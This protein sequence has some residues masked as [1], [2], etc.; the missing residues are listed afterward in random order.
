MAAGVLLVNCTGKEQQPSGGDESASGDCT[1]KL[2]DR[3]DAASAGSTVTLDACTY[4]E[5]VV[6][7]KNITLVGQ[8][9]T[10]I[11]GTDV[12]SEWSGHISANTVPIFATDTE[13]QT[14]T[15]EC[16]RPE[17]ASW[18]VS[19]SPRLPLAQ[20]RANLHWTVHVALS[21]ATNPLGAPLRLRQGMAGCWELRAA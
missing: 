17:Q 18:M 16:S 7:N 8:E 3:I 9:G 1:T 19:T 10:K 20:H 6:V 4:R 13:C 5:K 14:G 21:L 15:S 2:A 11:K 12:W